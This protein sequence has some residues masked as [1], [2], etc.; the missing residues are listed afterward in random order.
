MYHFT[1]IKTT[2]CILNAQ[3]VKVISDNKL[4]MKKSYTLLVVKLFFK[5]NTYVNL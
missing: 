3:K 5:V 1:I 4:L 2:H